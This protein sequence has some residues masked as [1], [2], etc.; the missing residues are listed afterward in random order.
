MHCF[1]E[2]SCSSDHYINESLTIKK[3]CPIR[4]EQGAAMATSDVI[5]A[6]DQGLENAIKTT[7]NMFQQARKPNLSIL[8][9]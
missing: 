2:I 6:Y 5:E 4:V 1:R 8:L 7:K 9:W 3:V